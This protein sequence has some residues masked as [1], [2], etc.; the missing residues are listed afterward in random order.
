MPEPFP[1]DP[2]ELARAIDVP[3]EAWPGNC[4][5]IACAVKDLVPVEGM[6]LARGDWIGEVADSSVYRRSGWLQHSWLVAPDGRIL[7]P[8][9]WAIVSPSRPSVYLGVNDCYD[10]GGRM[11]A[12]S[13][14]PQFPG[15]HDPYADLVVDMEPGL[16]DELADLLGMPGAEAARLGD[17]LRYVLKD[18]PSRVPDAA[19]V[20]GVLDRAGRRSVVPVDSWLRVMEPG[21][22]F[23]RTG[24][25]RTFALP[26]VPKMNDLEIVSAIFNRFLSV[27][28][29]PDIEEEVEEL[30]YD[31]ERD[32]WRNLNW[33]DVLKSEVPVRFLPRE[34]C[35]TLAVIAGELLGKGFGEELKVERYA[36]SLGVGCEGL[37]RILSEFGDRAGYDLGWSVPRSRRKAP[38]EVPGPALTKASW[39][40]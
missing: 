19:E 10:E 30:G 18:D 4:H 14:P 36:A 24:A 37:D 25:N 40:G 13:F 17:A 31:V 1:L 8:T 28:A 15:S 7:D 6:R 2:E 11:M 38:D 39:R 9:R 20:F 16:R 5:G 29:R 12:M 26:P 27:E 23:C 32:L 22:L 21:Q 33:L 35:D 34:M 3:L